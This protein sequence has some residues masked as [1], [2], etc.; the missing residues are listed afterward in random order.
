MILYYSFLALVPV[1]SVFLFLVVLR[2]PAK[3]AMP[4]A[5]CVTF[6]VGFFLWKV[7]LAQLLASSIQG[8]GIAVSILY[9]V[10]GAV[11]L[12]NAL[13]ESGAVATIRQGFRDI[14]PDRRIQAI[15][16]AWLFGSFIEG[17][18]G[19]GT[20][21]AVAAPLLLALGFPAMAAVMVALVIQ[22]TPVSFGAVGTP[23][24][25]GVSE[26]LAGSDLVLANLAAAEISFSQYIRLVGSYVG[27]FHAI[28]GTAIPLILS[29]MLTRFYGANRSWKEGLGIWRFALFAGLA[30][31][32]PYALTAILIGPEF[33]SLLGGL[34]GLFLVVTAARRRWL[35]P[36]T[37]W[38]F[39]AEADWD[40][41]WSGS[42]MKAVPEGRCVMS[43]WKAWLPYV[44][45]G[46]LLLLSRLNMFPFKDWLQ[47][48][49]L[50]WRGILGTEISL[51]LQPLYLPGTLFLI[52]V[53][54]TYFIQRMELGEAREAIRDSAKMLGSTA[55]ALAFAVPMARMF[56]NS[57][58]NTTGLEAMPIVLAEGM[59]ALAGDL[60]PLFAPL[61][62]AFGAFIAGSNTISNMMFS[63]FQFGVAEQIGASTLVVVAMQAVGGAAGNMICVHNVVAAS[64]TVGLSGREGQLIR[65]VLLPMFYYVVFAGVLA[66]LTAYLF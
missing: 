2:W 1:V 45:V 9:I 33:P 10:F 16:V 59:A 66:M 28:V 37:I 47:S 15:I 21:A 36:E 25:I 17:A 50:E 8:L 13:R 6:L 64:A 12:L 5:W 35:V 43:I 42:A 39:P 27:V 54:L 14:S 56:I 26:G 38:D 58:V 52:V 63:L 55:V 60:W 32:L 29:C 57:G 18:S 3:R 41:D 31:T 22:S 4:L 65:R 20:P 11:L 49:T 7:P 48:H 53:A 44:L 51:I 19:F 46:L 62:G 40:S 34:I 61:T 30:F 24:L 23:I